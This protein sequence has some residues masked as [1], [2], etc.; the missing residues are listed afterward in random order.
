MG[1]HESA[2]GNGLWLP[3]MNIVRTWLQWGRMNLHAEMAPPAS[4]ARMFILASMGPHESACGNEEKRKEKEQK[5]KGFNGA[6]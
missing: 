3:A 4:I 6:A 2:C 5:R 1:P